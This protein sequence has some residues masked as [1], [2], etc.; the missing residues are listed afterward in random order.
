[1]SQ[2]GI[3]LIIVGAIMLFLVIA[4][5]VAGLVIGGVIGAITNR[6][7]G[8]QV[9]TEQPASIDEL[10]DSYHLETGSLEVN[11]KDVEFPGGTTDLKANVDNGA[12]AVVVPKGV[13]VRAHGEVG[14]GVLN[15]LGS[16]V[17]GDNLDRDYKSKGYSQA[18]RRLSLDLSAGTG[19]ISVIRE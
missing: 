17:S 13:A 16:D 9:R 14:E 6:D 7:G 2:R 1:M 15:I 5:V 3:A 19:V 8:L 11:L 18:A 10:R 4:A 12:L